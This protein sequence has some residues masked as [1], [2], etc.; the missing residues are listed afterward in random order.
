MPEPE[1]ELESEDSG[2]FPAERPAERYVVRYGLMRLVAEFAARGPQK[3]SRN[4]SVIVRS[5]RGVE[6]GEILCQ[7]TE[8]T[9]AY[10][11]SH[12][13]IGKILRPVNDDDARQRDE[14]YQQER[15]EFLGC[16]E[17]I[18]ERKLGMQLVD[19]EHLLG[20]ER[21]IFYYLAEQRVDFRDLVKALAK[22]YKTRI[23]MRQIGVRDEAKLLAD[24]G[25][26]GKPVCCNT[27]LREMPP[28]SMKMAKIQKATL[29]P[30]KISGRCGRLKCC[31][32]Y[33]YDTYE[34]YRRDLPKVGN[35]VMT[36]VGQGKVIAQEI[37][38]R[39]ILVRY[40]GPRDVLTDER[41]VL[42]VIKAGA[43][44]SADVDDESDAP[45][46]PERN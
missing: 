44:S 21:L 37:L 27:H 9:A 2:H 29:D 31:L 46:S 35:L 6:W 39:K 11:E 8:R 33:E 7:A 13:S 42:T 43:R 19:V 12:E 34:E 25:D 10:L 17:M 5:S 22:R 41:D 20:G 1:A 32:R 30:A 38:A 28:V 36:R 15:V 16:R 26:C 4:T 23:E 24:Y 14:V 3:F 45:R 40:D 18:G